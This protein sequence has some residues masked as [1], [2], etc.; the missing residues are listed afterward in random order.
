MAGITAAAVKA[1]RERTGLPMMD[2]KKALT[3]AEGDEQKATELL[4]ERGLVSMEKRSGRETTF[5]RFGLYCGVDKPV[6]AIVEVKCESAPVMSNEEFVQFADDLAEAFAKDSSI[7]NAEELLAK[8]SPSNPGT[9]LQATKEDMYNRIREVFNIGRLQR[10]DGGTG[11][12]CHN[13]GTISGVL[14]GVTGGTDENAKDV[15]MHIA[16][17][18][19]A[20]LGV[21]DLDQDAIAKEREVL[22]TAAIAEGKPEN[23]VDKMVEGRLRNYYAERALTEQAFVKDDKQ[24]VGKFA[25]ASGMSLNDFVHW[26]LGDDAEAADE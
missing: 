16:A 17:M 8:D 3:D 10:I 21:A 24:T 26:E 20:A 6:G 13:S 22:R 15:C 5:G 11:S 4:R 14:L 18:R 2:C 23:I 7:S 9:T 12:Y 1:L 25:E 19:P